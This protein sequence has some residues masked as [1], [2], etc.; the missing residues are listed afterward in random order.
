[1][2]LYRMAVNMRDSSDSWNF[3]KT[4]YFTKYGRTDTDTGTGLPPGSSCARNLKF[5]VR[6]LIITPPCSNLKSLV[7]GLNIEGRRFYSKNSGNLQLRINRKQQTKKH[8]NRRQKC[9]NDT[10]Y[11]VVLIDGLI[12]KNINNCVTRFS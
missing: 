11:P 8:I 7:R 10:E 3:E 9:G 6:G 12:K 1:M 2:F 5:L 4:W